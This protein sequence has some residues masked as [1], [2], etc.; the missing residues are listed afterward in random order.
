APAPLPVVAPTAP[1]PV[2]ATTNGAPPAA[3]GAPR[4]THQPSNAAAEAFTVYQQALADSHM[5]YL[6]AMETTLA[7]TQIAYMKSLE[8]SYMAYSGLAPV[9]MPAPAF[10]AP[11]MALPAPAFQPPQ[12]A[13]P[14]PMALP[15]PV[16]VAPVATPAPVVPQPVAAP[17]AKPA[18]AA[19]ARPAAPAVDLEKLMLEV[20]AEK[21]GY[22]VE[23]LTMEMALEADLGVDSIKRVEILSAVQDRVPNLPDFDAGQMASLRTLGEIV[24]FMGK[25]LAAAPAPA[26]VAAPAVAAPAVAAP[27]VGPDLASLEKLMLEVVAEKTGYPVEM[28][29]MEMALEAD[30][31]VDSIK[32][33]EILSAVQ[34]RVPGLPDFD[35]GQ[36]ASLRTLGEIVGFMGKG[37]A[38]APAA[39]AAAP[40]QVAAPVPASASS[41][42]APT[43]D[44]TALMLEVVAEK[45]GYPVE[46]LN[47]E[48][49]LEADLGVDSIKRVEILSAVQDRAPGLPEFDAGQ[50]ASLRTLGQIVAFMG[51]G[52]AATPAPVAPP[53][54]VA[55]PVPASASSPAAPTADL[56]ALMLEVVAEKTGYPVEMLNLEMALEADLGVDSIK[57]VEIL[58]AVQDRAPGLP[59]FDAGQMASMRTLGQI[60]AFMGGAAPSQAAEMVVAAAPTPAAVPAPVPTPV[61]VAPA[62]VSTANDK[63]VPARS[64]GHGFASSGGPRQVPGAVDA[65]ASGHSLL[66]R[67]A[68]LVLV[69]QDGT[70]VADALVMLLKA[71]GFEAQLV[72]EVVGEPA[73]FV[74]LG[75]LAELL[76]ADA[77]MAVNRGAFDRA[78]KLAAHFAARGGAYVTVQD[79]GGDFGLTGRAGVRAWSAGLAGLAKTAAQE[80]PQARVR[81]IDVERGGRTPDMLAATLANELLNGGTEL[82]VG[83]MEDGR[84]VTVALVDAEAPAGTPLLG[85]NDVVVA[86][87]GA[88]G[89]TASTLIALAK[90][91]QPRMILLGRSPLEDEPEACKGLTDGAALK[92]ALLEAAKAEGQSMTPAE[93]GRKVNAVVAGREVRET[94]K[95]LRKA[96]SEALYLEADVRDASSLSAALAPIRGEWGPIT[97]LV[98]GA[99]VLADKRIQDKTL[100]Q[101]D[102][103]FETKVAGLRALLG[104]TTGDPLKAIVLFS[105]VA[106]R[107]GNA[108]QAD[109][110]MA[111]EVLNKVAQAEAGWRGDDCLVKSLNWGPWAGGMVTP[112][113][114][115]HFEKQGVPLLAVDTGAAMLVAELRDVEPGPVE[116][117][118][119]GAAG[120]T[121][122]APTNGNGN[123]AKPVVGGTLALELAVAQAT[124]DFLNGHRIHEVPV[125][126]AVMVLEWFLQAA[127]RARPDLALQAVR[128][129]KVLKGVQLD[130]FN[131]AGDKFAVRA[132]ES[133]EGAVTIQALELRGEDG[134][135][136]YAAT[137]EMVAPGLTPVA[138][139][140]LPVMALEACPWDVTDLY[141]EHL[142]HTGPF[143][144]VR[145][146][147]GV[148][149]EGLVGGLAGLTEMNWGGG[150]WDA[151]VAMLDGGLQLARLWGIHML[152]RPSLPTSLGEYRAYFPG[153]ARGPVRCEVR[154]RVAAKHRTLTDIRFLDDAGELLAELRG[155]E[156]HLLPEKRPAAEMVE[157]G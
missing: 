88:R 57:R 60:V 16:A 29:T 85:S 24:A 27:A 68:G 58:S 35:A 91:C 55:A 141:G 13:V 38:S 20:V 77:A 75:G 41:P 126:P 83:L 152:G 149:R 9:A 130:H 11:P 39:P 121:G 31:G 119:T 71:N 36:M 43:A 5:A 37:L 30:L 51:Q 143:R 155:V 12:M 17:I 113:L 137:V 2:P 150:P 124:H 105:S 66:D 146:L 50:M 14:A 76:T 18:P 100:E 95:Q 10:Q 73:A 65:K 108:G 49:A 120:A 25:G 145:T 86:S 129:L 63:I 3:I 33:V 93:L 21:T 102:L 142:F 52:L 4:M 151:D 157:L 128:D 139:A 144:V 115:A 22:P 154:A 122:P 8:S 98:H 26:T 116:V 97:A 94:L 131:G 42:A 47:L 99:G 135:L 117:L 53:V 56:T 70:G 79:T 34:D 109:Y 64:D 7:Q 15:L 54:Q 89:V 153:P 72:T 103:V 125:V 106:G 46:M 32:R 136:H 59:E 110:A 114:A 140:P 80:W 111:N 84:R 118:L 107:H 1:K 74:D 90:A 96:G 82:E 147:E 67:N 133:V 19:V 123:G 92:R 156:M 134:L 81:A 127:R 69:S 45:T 78:H 138:P 44:L 112:E 104:A 61:P 132:T 23:M 40:V 148:S 101:F 48:M 6:K 28:L 62:P 87:G